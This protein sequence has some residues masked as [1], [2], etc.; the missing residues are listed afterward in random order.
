LT[1]ARVLLHKKRD[2]ADFQVLDSEFFQGTIAVARETLA[3]KQHWRNKWQNLY[4]YEK[5]R[6]GYSPHEGCIERPD[7]LNRTL[8][9]CVARA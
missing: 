1:N 6:S 9:I 2:L 8:T 5:R 3:H 7:L 4:Q